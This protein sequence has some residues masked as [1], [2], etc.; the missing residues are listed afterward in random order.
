MSRETVLARGRAFLF[1][2]LV[3]TCRIERVTGESTNQTTGVVTKTWA[4]VYQGPCRIQAPT[5]NRAGPANIAEATV[6]LPPAELQLPVVG[7]ENV[8]FDQ[9]VTVLTCVNDTE[10]VNRVYFVAGISHKSH[11]TTRK[12]PLTERLD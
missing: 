10:M 1:A 9:R 6:R 2:A 5:A 7:T 3:D 4:T 11:A 8:T 12:L